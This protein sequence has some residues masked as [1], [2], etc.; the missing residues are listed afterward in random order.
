[1]DQMGEGRGEDRGEGGKLH[2]T[3]VGEGGKLHLTEVGEGEMLI[4]DQY[5]ICKVFKT[6]H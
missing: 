4:S 5:L 1:M 2:L 6:A 3:E